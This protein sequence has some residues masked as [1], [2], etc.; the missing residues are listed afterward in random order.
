VTFTFIC[1]GCFST[2]VICR[3]SISHICLFYALQLWQL[4]W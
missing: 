3:T 2:L 1:L 4:C